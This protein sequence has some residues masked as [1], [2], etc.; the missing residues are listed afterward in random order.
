MSADLAYSSERNLQVIEDA[1]ATPYIPFKSNATDSKGG[2]WARLFDYFS[3]NCD[4]FVAHYHQRLNAESTFS[5]VK[6]KFGDSVRSKIDV[7]MKHE[8]LAKILCHNIC[9]LISAMNELGLAP[10]FWKEETEAAVSA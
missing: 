3:F 4:E 8:V 1:G 9:C 6:A 5:M 7:A 2:I 10:E